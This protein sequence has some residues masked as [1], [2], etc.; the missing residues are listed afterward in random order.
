MNKNTFYAVAAL[1]GTIIGAGVLGIPY[2]FAKS[3]VLLG[4]CNLVLVGGVV[5]L[6]NL[7][8][9]EVTLRTRKSHML[10][11]LAERFLGQ[12]GKKLMF[13]ALFAVIWGAMIAYLIG[14]GKSL[15]AISGINT[16]FGLNASLVFSLIFFVTASALVYLGLRAVTRGEIILASA[17][18][19]VILALCVWCLFNANFSNMSLI[20]WS[21]LFLPYGVIL[22]ATHG[23]ETIPEMRRV[24]EQNKSSLKKAILLGTCIPL[25]L[26]ALFAILTIGITGAA[27]TEIATIG[28]GDSLGLGAILLGN[29]FAIFAMASS[30]II[31]GLALKDSLTDGIRGMKHWQAFILT[32][33]LPLIVFLLGIHSFVTVI[34]ITGALACGVGGI[35]IAFMWRA[36]KRKG[37]RRPE[38]A[39]KWMAASWLLIA[40]FSLGIVYTILSVAGIL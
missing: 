39:I 17:T 11:K 16:M 22:F 12:T 38:F 35:L 20:R 29:L 34:S 23:T 9:G 1:I 24:L 2:T 7:M 31:L 18:V 30:Y 10:P 14:V 25:V 13:V 33:S 37:N 6:M 27:T 3:G 5:L 28:L 8:L 4:L 36:A 26:Y 15:V 32:I 21:G 40:V 19:L